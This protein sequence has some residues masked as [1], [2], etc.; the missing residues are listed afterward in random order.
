M[1]EVIADLRVRGLKMIM[2][3][4]RNSKKSKLLSGRYVGDCESVGDD[5]R[6]GQANTVITSDLIDKVTT[7]EETP[8]RE[9]LQFGRRTQGHCK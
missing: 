8:E 6:P 4:E 5:Q 1:I 7:T 2:Q 9:S 3:I